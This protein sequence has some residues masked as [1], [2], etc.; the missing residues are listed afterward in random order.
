MSKRIFKA[1]ILKPVTLRFGGKELS[2]GE[3]VEV[4]NNTLGKLISQGEAKFHEDLPGESEKVEGKKLGMKAKEMKTKLDELGISY[5][6][7]ATKSE[8]EELLEPD[9]GDNLLG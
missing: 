3:V 6:A 4:D 8:L 7:N 2:P 1:K 9:G 5:G